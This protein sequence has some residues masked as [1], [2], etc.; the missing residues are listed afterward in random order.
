MHAFHPEESQAIDAGGD[1]GGSSRLR[2]LRRNDSFVLIPFYGKVPGSRPCPPRPKKWG[3][4]P[5][6]DGGRLR[7]RATGR[8]L[9]PFHLQP[10]FKKTRDVIRH[11]IEYLFTF[12]FVPKRRIAADAGGIELSRIIEHQILH[13]IEQHA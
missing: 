10:S 5:H 1:N 12:F 13:P 3:R 4:H 2:S 6:L 9:G 8:G 7:L 11:E